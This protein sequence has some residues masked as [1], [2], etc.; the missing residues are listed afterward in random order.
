MSRL[1]VVLFGPPGAG[2]TTIANHP[3]ASGLTTYD[4]DDPQWKPHGESFFRRGISRLADD[5][6]AQA[7]IIR[8]GATSS[9]R[10]RTIGEVN[11]THAFLILTDPA[12]CHYRVGHRRREDQR[13]SQAA[14]DTW[15]AKLDRKDQLP[16]WPGS[17][18]AALAAPALKPLP[19]TRVCKRSP[20]KAGDPRGTQDWKRLRAQVYDEETHCCRCGLVVDQSL[21]RYH[22]MGRTVHHLD[23]VGRGYAG[24][25]PRSRVR[26]CHRACNSEIGMNVSPIED[27]SLTVNIG[28]I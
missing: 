15:Y 4:R 6:N 21:S 17:W 1:V 22:P 11:A 23:P 27:R 13:Y 10:R 18:D 5:P 20:S 3:D 9:A 8:S 26:L 16:E 19:I 25:P 24:V 2:K 7:V 14:I 12:T 28:S